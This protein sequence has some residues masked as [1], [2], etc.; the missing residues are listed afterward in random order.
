M[1]MQTLARLKDIAPEIT[2]LKAIQIAAVF[3]ELWKANGDNISRCVTGTAGVKSAD[4]KI[5]ALSRSVKRTVQN[6]FYDGPTQVAID[7]LLGTHVDEDELLDQ[8]T[9]LGLG[10]L[11]LEAA[12][13]SRL[14]AARASI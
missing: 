1:L 3:K 5:T 10:D 2:E 6:N 7:V 14:Q 13:N 9:N 11:Q 4:R 8:E 12:V